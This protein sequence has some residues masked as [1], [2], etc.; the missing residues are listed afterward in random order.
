MTPTKEEQLKECLTRMELSGLCNE[1]I[2]DFQKGQL[3][4][5]ERLG[6]LYYLNDTEMAVVKDFE[7]EHNAVVYH[8]LHSNTE[9]GELLALLYVSKYKE[10]WQTDREDL[11][12]NIALSY[13]YNVDCPDFSEFGSIGFAQRFGGL[14]RTA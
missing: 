5:T 9:F 3:Y 7:K 4:K 12:D 8:I 2:A 6:I 11:K 14:V 10:E 1:V 13:V